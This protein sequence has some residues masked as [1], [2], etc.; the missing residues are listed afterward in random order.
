MVYIFL[1]A[2]SLAMDA[3][4]VSVS[5][6]LSAK[7]RGIGLPLMMGAYFG[8]FQFLM[9][10][11]GWA[12]GRSVAGFISALSPWVAF[13]LLEFIGVRMIISAKDPQENESGACKITHGRLLSLA[14]ATSI[15][16]LAVGVSFA[17]MEQNIL[18]CAAIIGAV[19]FGLSFLGGTA[20]GKLGRHFR[21]H[22][23]V[24]GGII[25]SAIGLKILLEA[26][27]TK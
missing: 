20:G 13:G 21:S 17:F 1:I 12:L 2:I 19:A 11:L 10:V 5:C 9:T 24:L 23:E 6:G 22:T 15:D 14:V 3:F 7:K 26:V 27:I 16:A 8:S 25:L 18:I 4:A